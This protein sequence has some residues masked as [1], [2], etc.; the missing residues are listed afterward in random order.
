MGSGTNGVRN[1]WGQGTNGVRLDFLFIGVVP[2]V[3]HMD[4]LFYLSNKKK[5]W[6]SKS[7]SPAFSFSPN[8]L[9]LSI[10]HD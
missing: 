10:T 9:S 3:C 6:V 8:L 5:F 7:I 4:V 1:K 2:D